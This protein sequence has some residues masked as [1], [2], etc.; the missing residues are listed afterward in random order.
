MELSSG[1]L[2]RERRIR[3]KRIRSYISRIEEA[4]NVWGCYSALIDNLTT[5]RELWE[6]NFTTLFLRR[7]IAYWLER[8]EFGGNCWD[9]AREIEIILEI[10]TK[11]DP[12]TID[13]LEDTIQVLRA[14]HGP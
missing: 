14:V 10:A 4:L 9:A 12:K 6:S 11:Q 5:A 13:K 3:E 8:H 7:D 1:L 2:W